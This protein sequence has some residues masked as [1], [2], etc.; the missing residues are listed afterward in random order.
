MTPSNACLVFINAISTEGWDRDGLHD[1][2]SDGLVRN[3]ASKCANTI[4]VIHAS[5]IRLVD[6]WIE[7]PN[8]TAAVLAHVP[9]QDSGRALVKLLYGEVGFSGKLPYT[10]AKNESDYPVYKP[11]ALAFKGDTDP[12]CDYTEGVYLDYRAFDAKNI[13]PRFEFG[14]GL[15]YTTFDY[16]SLSIS[17][18]GVRTCFSTS[19]DELWQ[20]VAKVHVGVVNSGNVD[21][22]EIAQLY[23][24]IPGAPP[25]QLRGFEKFDLK[26]GQGGRATFELTRRDLSQWDVVQ[27]KWVLL[28]GDYKIYVGASSRDIRLTGS[29]VVST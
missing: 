20:V 16:S 12:Q 15:S 25:K 13:T 4:V 27:Q 18:H 5:G 6:Q 28:P 2:F 23:V 24:G 11:C 1:E 3:V 22:R 29:I 8:V 7:H 19:L 9:G 26:A 17:A 14:Y 10:I 21:G